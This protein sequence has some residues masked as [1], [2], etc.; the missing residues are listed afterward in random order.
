MKLPTGYRC[1]GDNKV[2]RLKKSLYG[3]HQALKQW[4]VKLSSKLCE[5]GFVR[6]YANYSLFAYRKGATSMALLVYVDDIV[7]TSNDAEACK[8]FK[9]I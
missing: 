1:I 9:A 2:C 7:L 5:Y 3:L 6:S 8:Q 4:F